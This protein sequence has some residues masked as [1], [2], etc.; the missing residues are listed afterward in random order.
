MKTLFIGNSHT[1][2]ND[3]PELYRQICEKNGIDMHIT[4][5]T[6]G[7][8]GFEEHIQNEQTR[9]NILFGRYDFVI[10]QHKAHPMG[11]I[12]S[13]YNAAKQLI[14][15]IRQAGSRPIFYQTWA[16]KGDEEYQSVMSKIY[17]DMGNK[18][19]AAVAPVGNEWQKAR[20]ENPQIELF[21]KDGQH[22]SKA[23]SQLAAQVIFNT[24]FNK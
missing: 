11:D 9:F 8:I 24:V 21:Y 2:F 19:S 16:K 12:D 6:K 4:M 18:F 20:K 5:L 17:D 1:Y 15:W 7:G 23:G 13:M 14:E 22:A 10:L 3:L